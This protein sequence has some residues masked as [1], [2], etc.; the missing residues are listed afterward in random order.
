MIERIPKLSI[1][2]YV[3][4]NIIKLSEP[5]NM[6]P[7]RSIS[8]YFGWIG[9]GLM[10][11]MNVYSIRKR[12]HIAKN[13]GRL[14]NWLNFHIFCGLL[15]PTFILFHCAFKVR[16]LVGISFWS[17]IISASS[18][19]VGRYFYGQLSR[20]K[21]ELEEEIASIKNK[22]LPE[23][24]RLLLNFDSP[25]IKKHENRI[26]KFVGCSEVGD[27]TLASFTTALMGDFRL[28]W[29]SPPRIKEVSASLNKKLIR[30]GLTKRK[31]ILYESFEKLMG[32]W[33]IFHTPFAFFMFVA[34]FIHVISALIFITK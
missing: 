23:F 14:K 34:A 12:I 3:T 21:K 28:M 4:I 33:H 25:E 5:I 11:I 17:M 18:G 30:Y 29:Q 10:I 32:Y 24:S 6:N 8:Y 16:G 31:L 19:I 2:K 1:I 13:W 20:N 27:S 9:L 7:G 15:G 26:L 22:F